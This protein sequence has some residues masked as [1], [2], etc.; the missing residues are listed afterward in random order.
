ML[1]NDN[2]ARIPNATKAIKQKQFEVKQNKFRRKFE[3]LRK[4]TSSEL[5]DSEVCGEVV[6]IK[7]DL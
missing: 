3:S 6:R 2:L 4:E 7:V 5:Y 1:E